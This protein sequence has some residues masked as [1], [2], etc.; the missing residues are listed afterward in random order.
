MSALQPAAAPESEHLGSGSRLAL[1]LAVVLCRLLTVHSFPIYDDAFITYRY[2]LN[3]AGGHGLVFN[4]GADWEPVLGTTAPGYAVLLAGLSA[5]GAHVI[6]ASLAINFVCDAASAWMLTHL[7]RA[8]P[9]AA[10]LAVLAFASIPEVGRISVGGMEPPLFIALALGAVCALQSRHFALGGALAALDCTVRPE[11]VLLVGLLPLFYVRSWRDGL[12]YLAPVLAIGV[13]YASYLCHVYGSPIPQSVRAKAGVSGLK[14]RTYRVPDILS[15]SFG[16]STMMRILIPAAGLGYGIVF[17][18]RSQLRAF[19]AFA[20]LI[21]AA[22]LSAGVK[23]WGWY[24]YAPRVA[25]CV[26]FA[27]GT[28]ALLEFLGRATPRLR[29]DHM[30]A[31]APS[32]L[33]CVTVAA[34]L[35]NTRL[36][37]ER[38]TPCVYEKMGEWAE[39]AGLREGSRTIVASDIGAVGYFTGAR[40]LDSEGLVWPEA[41]Q[42]VKL[43]DVVRKH[44]PDYVILVATQF[45]VKPFVADPISQDYRPIRRFNT[46]DDAD[47]RPD[48]EQLPRWWEQDYIVY[49]RIARP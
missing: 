30:R 36:H 6:G 33:S 26:T 15:E 17:L 20:L 27:L 10:T 39:S 40:I 43:V 22:Y 4:P 35:V 1:V 24:F 11:A 29:V 23:T 46:T 34:V 9:V 21:V 5:L 47:L 49:E 19:V 25:W 32:L 41:R 45:R 48:P 31:W 28:D 14:P 7:L 12:R 2:A 16:P 37:P 44:R 13:L 38:V 42:L 18:W 3:L 8:R